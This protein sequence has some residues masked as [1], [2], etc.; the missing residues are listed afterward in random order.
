MNEALMAQQGRGNLE[1]LVLRALVRKLVGTGLLSEDDGRALLFDAAKRMNEVCSEQTDQVARSMVKEDL[2]PTFLGPW[3]P[4]PRRTGPAS[5]KRKTCGSR[6]RSGT[7]LS[8]RWLSPGMVPR[9]RERLPAPGTVLDG[10]QVSTKEE[11]AM[12]NGVK[13]NMEVIGADGVHVGTVDHVEGE[14]IKLKKSVSHGR[15]E[16][17]HHYIEL[18]FV[19]GVEGDRVRLSANAD[20]VVTLEEEASGKPVD[21]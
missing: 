16:G 8:G 13:E 4:S 5:G 12:T 7:G 9:W 17:H 20:V 1:S 11:R 6:G 19:A 10:R 14:R 15:H 18:G 2:S 3:S 21:L